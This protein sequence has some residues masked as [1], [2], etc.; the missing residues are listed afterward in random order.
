M[1]RLR[2]ERRSETPAWLN[3]TLPLLAIAA[4]LIL[5]SGLV[6]LAHADVEG[7]LHQLLAQRTP[8]VP[9]P[10]TAGVDVHQ[11]C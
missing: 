2:L 3:L 4:T 1:I 5:C 7:P 11:D 10:D 6:A 9:A 8:Q